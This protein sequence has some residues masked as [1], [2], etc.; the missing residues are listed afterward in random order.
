MGVVIRNEEGCLMGAMGKKLPFPLGLLEA[1]AR[2]MEEGIVLAKD[3]GFNEVII[4]GDAK[5]VMDALAN[6]DPQLIPSSIQKV[7]ERANF[8]LQAFKS[9]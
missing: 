4:E 3:L 7:I 1:E 6:S 8:R 5:T 9:W 2:A